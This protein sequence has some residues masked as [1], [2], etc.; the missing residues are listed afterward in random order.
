MAE[1]VNYPTGWVS[2]EQYHPEQHLSKARKSSDKEDY[3]NVAQR[4]VWFV[5]EQRQMIVAGLATRPYMMQTEAVEINYQAGYAI[6]KTT[7]RDVLGNEAT[8]YGTE[9]RADFGDFVEKAATKSRGRA[10][11][12]LGYGTAFAPELDEGERVVDTPRRPAAQPQ[13][14]PTPLRSTTTAE[15]KPLPARITRAAKYGF[16]GSPFVGA[17]EEW[18]GKPWADL[19]R[20]PS[21]EDIAAIDAGLNEWIA[22]NASKQEG[23]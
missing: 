17:C 14:Q 5:T 8:D 21:A 13:R 11:L 19:N 2:A 16:K 23:A 20:Q 4:M 15:E 9:S 6:F 3:L 7:I 12:S 1:T 10:L 18:T 22:K